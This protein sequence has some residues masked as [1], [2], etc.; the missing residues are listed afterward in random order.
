[1]TITRDKIYFSLVK[2]KGIEE[3][4]PLEE[5]TTAE[6]SSDVEKLERQPDPKVKMQRRESKASDNQDK[7]LGPRPLVKTASISA[8]QHFNGVQIETSD[9]GIFAGRIYRI[10]AQVKAHSVH[11]K[12]IIQKYSVLSRIRAEKRSRFEMTQIY[13][14]VVLESQQC[15]FLVVAL[16]LAVRSELNL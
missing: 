12:N 6:L 10:R 9:T 8:F 14:R 1:M 4:T 7:E 13:L 15:R 3:A 16:I 5:V 2:D 11:M